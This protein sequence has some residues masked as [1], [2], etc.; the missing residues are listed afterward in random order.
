MN[1]LFPTSHLET[2]AQ[3]AI[4]A[5]IFTYPFIITKYHKEYTINDKTEQIK[6]NQNDNHIESF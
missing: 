6:A 2:I 1:K 4:S 3:K 5:A